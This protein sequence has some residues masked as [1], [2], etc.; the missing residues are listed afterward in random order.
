MSALDVIKTRRSIRNF[1]N[2]PVSDE[3]AIE[4][5]NAARLAPTGGN[6]QRW[7]FIYVKDPQVLRM[8]KSCCP[9]F[10]GD[11]TAGIVAGI[12]YEEEAFGGASYGSIVGVLDIG[13]A[14]E[15]ILLAAHALGLG[16]CAIASFNA[17]CLKKVLNA[18]EHF[19]PVLAFSIGHPD[20]QPEMPPKKKL[21]E[22]VY[23][24]E[25]GKSWDKLEGL[26]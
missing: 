3:D 24:D 7:K 11:A 25:F 22:I 20:G 13:F 6:R 12:E 16:G 26:E 21:S 19:R 18:P 10:Y 8:I 1:I 2:E 15:N 17:S 23:I 5:L 9:G 4:I 14:A